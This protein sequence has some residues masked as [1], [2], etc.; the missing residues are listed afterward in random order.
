MTE[1][2]YRSLALL[3][4]FGMCMSEAFIHD[5]NRVASR[6]FWRR[7]HGIHPIDADDDT[8]IK[9]YFLSRNSS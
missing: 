4:V 7:G 9:L 1:V 6:K 8:A 3:A 2:S 5:R